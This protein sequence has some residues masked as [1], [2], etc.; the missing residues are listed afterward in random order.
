M[1][2]LKETNSIWLDTAK[3]PA[4]PP[5][6]HDTRADVCVVGAGIAGMTTA[7]L[8]A[9][10]GRSVV[11]LDKGPIAGGMTGLTTAHLTNAIDDRICGLERL[12]GEEAARLAVESHALAIDRIE[13][14][15]TEERIPCDFERLD[16]YLFLPPG[17]TRE[18]LEEELAAAHRAGLGGVEALETAPFP[19]FTTG[20]CLRFPQQAQFH[21][22][23][24]LTGLARAIERQGGR[25]FNKTR[26]EAVEGGTDARVVTD[27]GLTVACD[28]I[29]VATNTPVNDVVTMHTK[30]APYAT[31]VVAAR[32][33]EA[34]PLRALY[35]DTLDPYHY[36]RFHG[37][38]EVKGKRKGHEVLIVG[39]EDH[40]SGQADD[41]AARFGRLE[42]WAREHF[43]KMGKVEYRWSGIVMEPVDRLA[44]IGRNPGDERNVY[45]ATGDSGM[46]MTHGTIAGMLLTDLIA[47]RE[48]PWASLYDPSRVTLRAGA[49]FVRENLNVA[50]QYMKG[51]FT[52]GEVA[53]AKEI[54][55]GEGGVIRRGLRKIA[56]YRDEHGK[57]HERSAVCQHLGCIVGWNST[58][59]TWD[60]PCH[61]AR[62]DPLGKVI[63]G[64]AKADLPI[65]D[66]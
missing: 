44:F 31:Y 37:V 15:V 29:V 16:G 9:R 6:R 42:A 28:N 3:A 4:W 27:K 66:D 40:K 17:G 19:D 48:N 58:A 22:V 47:G 35:W 26:V 45:I 51:Y 30:Q 65:V 11:V 46:G 34:P 23:R 36:V 8:L 24:Y 13:A 5:L 12:H 20:A 56:A 32:L 50:A 33:P 10:E 41:G 14:A 43:P 2:D 57:L 25:I 7:Y 55:R 64:P 38:P 62:Y 63:N 49:E 18:L 52:G 1:K 60:C 59:K 61:G 39:G 21:P 54:A 53:S